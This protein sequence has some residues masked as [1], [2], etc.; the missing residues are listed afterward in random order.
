MGQPFGIPSSVKSGH[1]Q[2]G[3]ENRLAGLRLRTS[4]NEKDES[5]AKKLMQSLVSNSPK[6]QAIV[7]YTAG[8]WINLHQHVDVIRGLRCR[9][10]GQDVRSKPIDLME[11]LARR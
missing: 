10:N 4:K 8:K 6:L 3:G 1:R 5:T 11:A 9:I 2:I 7:D